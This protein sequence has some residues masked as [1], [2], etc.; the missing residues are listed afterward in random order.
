MKEEVNG[1]PQ[2][3]F[4]GCESSPQVAIQGPVLDGFADVVGEDVF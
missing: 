3:W 2:R 1:L 4:L